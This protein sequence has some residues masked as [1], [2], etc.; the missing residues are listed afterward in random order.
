M[1]SQHHKAIPLLL[2]AALVLAACTG[3]VSE[4]AT[5]APTTTVATAPSTVTATTS[6]PPTTTT[7]EAGTS[8]EEMASLDAALAVKNSFFIAFNAADSTTVMGLFTVDA[9]FAD[10]FGS[11]DRQWFE[12]LLEWNTAQGTRY[13]PSDCSA[14][15]DAELVAF[16]EWESIEEAA[17]TGT[18]LASYA[19][20]WGRFLETNGCAYNE[21]C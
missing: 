16:G 6:K 5:T 17:T 19:V 3:E 1:R 13:T 2:A 12:E 11:S 4:S 20:E 10:T 15:A 8:P 7:T 9:E 21:S 14:E 18:L